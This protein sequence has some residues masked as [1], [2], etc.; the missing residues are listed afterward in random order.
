M[1][2]TASAW[3]EYIAL[4]RVRNG[5][6]AAGA[7]KRRR[8]KWNPLLHPRGAN[9][10][11]ISKGGRVKWR[12]LD[13]AQ[14]WRVGDVVD[15]NSKGQVK[16]RDTDG[17]ETFRDPKTLY[18]IPTPK[19]RINP[20]NWKQV[21]KQAGSNPG[22]FYEDPNGER[23]YVKH[24]PEDRVNNEI[25]ATQLYA[26]AGATVPEVTKS[27][28]GKKFLTKIE[29]S[30]DF[31]DIASADRDDALEAVA[32]DF[33]VDAWLGNWDAPHN[34]NIRFNEM[35]D[36][37]RVDTGGSLDYRARGAKK[38]SLF[39][40]VVGEIDSL[41][42]FKGVPNRLYAKVT[43]K[44]EEDGVQRILAIHPDEIRDTVTENGLPNSVATTLIARRAYLANYYG[45]TLPETTPEGKAILAKAATDGG[46]SGS[47][48]VPNAP[49]KSQRP[50][51]ARAVKKTDPKAMPFAPDSPVWLKAKL[52]EGKGQG[53]IW[54]IKTIAADNSTL[55]I[56]SHK[57]KKVITVKPDDVQILRANFTTPKAFYSD[58]STVPEVGDRVQTPAHGTGTVESLFHNYSKI[59][60]DDGTKRINAIG[61]L[62]KIQD[63]SK[64]DS[65]VIVS[66]DSAAS[67]ADSAT[68]AAPKKTRTKK[69]AIPGD[70]FDIEKHDWNSDPYP[71]VYDLVHGRETQAVM[72]TKTPSGKI[73][74]VVVS[75]DDTFGETA[76]IAPNKVR[77]SGTVSDDDYN[78]WVN[79][80]ST[81]PTTK[82]NAPTVP[83]HE[84][85]QAAIDAMDEKA[86]KALK[87]KK[88]SETLY[89][90]I[91]IGGTENQRGE[92]VAPEY[93]KYY[94]L[95]PGDEIFQATYSY[96]SSEK[97]TF[98]RRDGKMH[99]LGGSTAVRKNRA[100]LS[101]VSP[102]NDSTE[103]FE[104]LFAGRSTAYEVKNVTPPEFAK[105][106]EVLKQSGAPSRL[107]DNLGTY[108]AS[109]GKNYSPIDALG[110]DVSSRNPS[111][112]ST[113]QNV[114]FMSDNRG[115]HSYNNPLT[116]A[117]KKLLDSLKND[118]QPAF[119]IT[120]NEDS[121][122]NR[123]YDVYHVGYEEVRESSDFRSAGKVTKPRELFSP[124][125]FVKLTDEQKDFYFEESIYGQPVRRGFSKIS[126][127]SRK[128]PEDQ[129][130]KSSGGIKLDATALQFA[131]SDFTRTDGTASGEIEEAVLESIDVESD[132]TGTSSRF[133]W[134]SAKGRLSHG[135]YVKGSSY[136][137]P[138]NTRSS[139]SS[140][141]DDV[142]KTVDISSLKPG[143]K[144]PGFGSVWTERKLTPMEALSTPLPAKKGDLES[145]KFD[146]VI[147]RTAM[148]DT[149]GDTSSIIADDG[150]SQKDPAMYEFTRH[151]HG[152]GI[153]IKLA[154]KAFR[155]Y[156]ENESPSVKL[157]R[158]IVGEEFQRDFRYGT[159]YQGYGA[160]GNG[161]Y[162]SNLLATAKVYANQRRNFNATRG[163]TSGGVTNI[164][165][166]KGAVI[167]QQDNIIRDMNTMISKTSDEILDDLSK[168][169]L[170][171]SKADLER[172]GDDETYS[173]DPEIQAKVVTGFG[174]PNE[175]RDKLQ[176]KT[177]RQ[178]SAVKRHLESKGMKVVPGDHITDSYAT[179]INQK[180]HVENLN[181]S[182]TDPG[183]RTF[184]LSVGNVD[185][186]KQAR[187]YDET[188]NPNLII[189]LRYTPPGEQRRRTQ[190][191]NY[192]SLTS[193][194]LYGTDPVRSTRALG[195]LKG[196]NLGN[197]TPEYFDDNGN[198]VKNEQE[199]EANKARLS[200]KF[201]KYEANATHYR[202]DGSNK[203]ASKYDPQQSFYSGDAQR[204]YSENL[205]TMKKIARLQFGSENGRYAIANGID[206]I[207]L[208]RAGNEQYHVFTNRNAI[209]MEKN[210]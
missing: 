201:N 35:G 69:S 22:G 45:Y 86:A 109:D 165:V 38:G 105:A 133:G 198:L 190:F 179:M 17:N 158:G 76:I 154:P 24:M 122:G 8:A 72:V 202:T 52:D 123:V 104:R 81:T 91:P 141:S 25:A 7:F 90:A 11:F 145:G 167:E 172:I 180:L 114:T 31:G 75:T 163:A 42:S 126:D 132:K 85:R 71:K 187:A 131:S 89:R 156:V 147:F 135:A 129:Y 21:G 53:D 80:T 168:Q 174:R 139:G 49:A 27:P 30:D 44:H 181:M 200:E 134:V 130:L 153:P 23:W 14:L 183:E 40:P 68:P 50:S 118:G 162:S 54:T 97:H 128:L 150:S 41:K 1:G 107:I 143:E 146:D 84:R 92:K 13:S 178:A 136:V 46:D 125:K 19:A 148:R 88:I 108:T 101:S 120:K 166:K 151:L 127:E 34:D 26:L 43:K 175:A 100:A 138:P 205:S 189:G 77:V 9:G 208:G 15:I 55:D 159:F 20:N 152:D 209:V 170:L 160:F 12:D 169:D 110:V 116:P 197:T 74:G 82:T 199:F 119:V 140:G 3:S 51:L 207:Q 32:K 64:S 193:T 29:E 106:A 65:D 157:H 182:D 28:D 176:K 93:E 67:A 96:R 83:A 144:V 98:L 56:E 16:V 149:F 210:W 117:E 78:D 33:I 73:N 203:F 87:P 4:E 111:V 192:M 102:D 62:T 115:M 124:D 37:M 171:P 121:A 196:V 112:V 99:Y 95:Q 58:G 186:F 142:I 177:L 204:F 60:L 173:I 161:T 188:S 137:P 36:A 195:I 57:T 61:R 6:V 10:R 5:L 18:T 59:K 184:Q 113:V 79:G 94:S 185:I 63:D 39:G 66:S 48:S 164:A 47:T 103:M 194:P 206:V 2:Q 70:E 155:Q 191:H